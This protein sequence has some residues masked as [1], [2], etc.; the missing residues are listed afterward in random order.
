MASKEEI[1]KY[2]AQKIQ[3]QKKNLRQQLSLIG[4]IQNSKAADSKEIKLIYLNLAMVSLTELI[5]EVT[6]E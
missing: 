6:N 2:I 5:E 3:E 1:T 4:N